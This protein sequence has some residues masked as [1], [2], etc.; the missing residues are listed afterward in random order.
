[1]AIDGCDDRFDFII[2][3]QSIEDG[4]RMNYMADSTW[5]EG[6]DGLHYNDSINRFPNL[7]VSQQMADA[8]HYAS[9][10][11]PVIARF[12]FHRTTSLQ[13]METPERKLLIAPNPASSTCTV[14]LPTGKGFSLEVIDMSGRVVQRLSELS[15]NV[16]LQLESLRSGNYIVVARNHL[17]TMCAQLLLD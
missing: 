1:V 4:D 7:F 3:S 5:P 11:L 15:G 10:H 13:S 16:T 8:I 14:H 9:D 17:M 2:F 12:V 6:N